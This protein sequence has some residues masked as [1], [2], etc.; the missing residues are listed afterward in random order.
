MNLK[1]FFSLPYQKDT[2]SFERYPAI[3][4]RFD[5]RLIYQDSFVMA[6][7]RVVNYYG[8]RSHLYL[9]Y[10]YTNNS[11]LI[12]EHFNCEQVFFNDKILIK[13]ITNI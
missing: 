10:K 13:N 7:V 6:S 3:N 12:V 4:I 1:L 11:E 8:E 5:K 9:S 2:E